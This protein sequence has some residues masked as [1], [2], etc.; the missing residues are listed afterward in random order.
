MNY[1]AR[2]ERVESAS[3]H[4]KP[5]LCGTW[6][7]PSTRSGFIMD[8]ANRELLPRCIECHHHVGVDGRS[9]EG[10]P[11]PWVILHRRNRPRRGRT[12]APAALRTWITWLLRAHTWSQGAGRS[13]SRRRA[14]SEGHRMARASSFLKPPI[15]PIEIAAPLVPSR[16]TVVVFMSSRN[17]KPLLVA[18]IVAL[19]L[20]LQPLLSTAWCAAGS[21]AMGGDC[22]CQAPSEAPP[23]ASCCSQETPAPDPGDS[24]LVEDGCGCAFLPDRIPATLPEAPVVPGPALA[25][26]VDEPPS[27]RCWP[28][29]A[30]RGTPWVPKARAPGVGRPLRLLT[31]VFRL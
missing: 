25:A 7:Y 10:G 20:V 12:L 5:I 6:C 3:S 19:Q 14:H 17:G 29:I 22:C 28:P 11:E 26:V 2:V 23:S 8:L 21:E 1:A 27:S 16:A 18:L 4:I 24:A 9:L 15:L 13:S 31:R 30:R